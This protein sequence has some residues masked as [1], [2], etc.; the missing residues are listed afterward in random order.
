MQK[1]SLWD[2]YFVGYDL[3]MEN[4]QQDLEIIRKYRN[5]VAHNKRFTKED[6]DY[7]RKILN[8]FNRKMASAINNIEERDF[9]KIDW[10]VSYRNSLNMISRMM[11]MVSDEM[12]QKLGELSKMMTGNMIE[13]AKS[14]NISVDQLIPKST[15]NTIRQIQEKNTEMQ[16]QLSQVGLN[17]RQ[18]SGAMLIENDDDEKIDKGS[19]K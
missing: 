12:R 7:I 15:M 17:F 9:A 8:K 16:K 13:V 19:E 11:S 18:Q 2:D 1:R 6:Y 3:D 4:I 14:F 5:R 10:S